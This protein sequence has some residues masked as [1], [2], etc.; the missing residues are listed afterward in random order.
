MKSLFKLP[1]DRITAARGHQLFQ[2]GGVRQIF[3]DRGRIEAHVVDAERPQTVTFLRK[4]EDAWEARCTCAAGAEGR[5]LHAH[6]AMLAVQEG[7][8]RRETL[9]PFPESER[10]LAVTGPCAR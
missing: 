4:P 9:P 6:S 1:F 2:A 7:V 5:C 3:G 8:R 10:S